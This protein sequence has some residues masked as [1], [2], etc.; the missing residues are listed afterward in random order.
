[1]ETAGLVVRRHSA[2]DRRRTELRLTERGE[3]LL[4]PLAKLHLAQHRKHLPELMLLLS[5]MAESVPD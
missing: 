2:N 3:T 5:Q 1:M 4:A